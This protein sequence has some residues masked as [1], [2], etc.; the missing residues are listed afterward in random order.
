MELF[1]RKTEK[2]VD[3]IKKEALLEARA[4]ILDKRLIQ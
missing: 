1:K 3:L 4:E 2:E